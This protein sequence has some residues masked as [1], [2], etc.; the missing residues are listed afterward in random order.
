MDVIGFDH[1]VVHVDNSASRLAELKSEIEPKGFPFEPAWGK[2]TK[3]FKAANI[4]IGRQYFEIVHLLNEDGGGWP[5][6]WVG[7][8]NRGHRGAKCVFLQ[9]DSIHEI[10]GRLQSQGIPVRP[11]E[12]ITFRT[13]FGLLKKT[14][15]WDV[16]YLPSLPGC[17][18][19]IGFIQHDPDPRDRI[20]QFLV[21]NADENG[22]TGVSG[23]RISLPL[24]E[25][26][27]RFLSA[28]FPNAQV[29]SSGMSVP[30][31]FGFLE[32]NDASTLSV[33]LHANS[34]K[35]EFKGQQFAIENVVVKTY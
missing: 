31:S 35:E 18:L 30:V 6:T 17:D 28:V 11:P 4:W 13:M 22:I 12:R 2:G 9:T 15:P 16:L 32:L 24:G 29:T 21:P 8:Y 5:T 14:L 3:G 10:A 33:E 7:E 26:A 27:A 19:E 20:K 25:E 34:E 23:C 1:I